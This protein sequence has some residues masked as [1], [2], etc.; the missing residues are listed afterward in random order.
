[1]K[2]HG[3]TWRIVFLLL[4]LSS[5][6]YGQDVTETKLTAFDGAEGDWFGGSA[7]ISGDYALVG[8]YLDDNKNGIQSGG[9][10]LYEQRRER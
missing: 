10:Y 6:V 1:M 9:A 3:S 5:G 7:S 8:A 2:K 4:A